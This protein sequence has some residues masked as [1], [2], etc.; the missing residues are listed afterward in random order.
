MEENN[1]SPPLEIFSDP[2]TLVQAAEEKMIR[3]GAAAAGKN[4]TFTVALSG[5][6]TPRPLYTRL[7]AGRFARAIDWSRVHLF[8]G[9][10]RCVP[11]DDPRSNYRM[12]RE[13]LLDAVPIPPRNVHRIHG[14]EDPEV[15]A[16]AYERE[17]RTFFGSKGAEGPPRAGFDLVLLGLGGDGH[18]ASLFPGMPAVTERRRWVMAQFMEGLS[19][20][21]ITLTP[22]VINAAKEVIFL[23]SGA[24]KAPRL[25]DVLEG[26]LQPETLPAQMIKPEQ[27]G[28]LWLVD[29]AAAGRLKSVR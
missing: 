8:W 29:D 16:A 6:S 24:E 3:L 21:R 19:M 2:E 12:V 5:G 9:D 18:T 26:P 20:W 11:P 14:E 13:S 22:P 25:R 10:E 15:A 4:G 17:L 7:A 23:V 28:L 27:G 1:P